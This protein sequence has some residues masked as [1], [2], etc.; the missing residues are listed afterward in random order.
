MSLPTLK[1]MSPFEKC[2]WYWSCTNRVIESELRELDSKTWLMVR[3][4]GLPAQINDLL[5]LLDLP[6][7]PLRIVRANQSPL[8]VYRF[9]LWKSEGKEAFERWCGQEMDRWYPRWREASTPFRPHRSAS[10]PGKLGEAMHTV[11]SHLVWFVSRMTRR[12]ITSITKAS[13]KQTSTWRQV[14]TH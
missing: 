7:Y 12:V 13:S 2:C 5:K 1:V 6:Y 10:P 4:E 9:S 14:T 11:N 8:P 3:L